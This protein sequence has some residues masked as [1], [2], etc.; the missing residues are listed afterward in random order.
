MNKSVFLNAPF[1]VVIPWRKAG[2]QGTELKYAVEGWKRHFLDQ[3]SIIVVGEDDP[4]ME[5]VNFIYSKRVDDIPASTA[6]TS[7]MSAASRRS[8]K[9]SPTPGASSS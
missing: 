6:S 7:T 5:D 9:R 2:A 3:H 4:K 1:L 8:A